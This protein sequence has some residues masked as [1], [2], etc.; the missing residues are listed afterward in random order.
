ML[1]LLLAISDNF[2]T[3]PVLELLLEISDNFKTPPVLELLLAV[4]ESLSFFLFLAHDKIQTQK[5]SK[6]EPFRVWIL[7]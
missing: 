2:K 1:S 5:G 4:S 3:P 7:F 6:V